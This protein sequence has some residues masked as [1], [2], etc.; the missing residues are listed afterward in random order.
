[1]NNDKENWGGTFG[2]FFVVLLAF[3]LLGKGLQYISRFF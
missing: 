3:I 1:M 2:V